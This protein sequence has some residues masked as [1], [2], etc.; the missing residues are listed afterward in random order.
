MKFWI[1]GE[2]HES[3]SDD[4]LKAAGAVSDALNSALNNLQCDVPVDSWDVIGIV[5]PASVKGFAEVHKYEAD[6]R[7]LEFRLRIDYGQFHKAKP[8]Q[9][10]ELVLQ[11]ILRSI[12]LFKGMTTPPIDITSFRDQVLEVGRQH[13]WI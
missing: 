10:K 4:Y 8:K 6:K 2:I 7:D 11:M 12:E 3:I 1:S 5:L 9:K 13:G